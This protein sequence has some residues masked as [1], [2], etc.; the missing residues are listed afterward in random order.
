MQQKHVHII[1]FILAIGIVLLSSCG[2]TN[3]KRNNGGFNKVAVES[4][5][6]KA[7]GAGNDSV[8][9]RQSLDSLLETHKRDSSLMIAYYG[10]MGN[11]MSKHFDRL[12]NSSDIYYRRSIQLAEEQ[13]LYGMKIWALVNY[14]FYYYSYRQATEAMPLFMEAYFLMSKVADNEI[15]YPEDTFKKMGYYF[16][17]LGNTED[18]IKLL[19][20]AN[21][22][23]KAYQSRHKAGILDNLGLYYL[24]RQDTTAAIEHFLE[25]ESIALKAKDY[26]RYGKVLGNIALVYFNRG[27]YMEALRLINTDLSYSIA[28]NS[29]QNTMYA[30]VLK[31]KILLAMDSVDAAQKY[32]DRAEVY[33]RSKDYLTT[34]VLDI[35]R[36]RLQIAKINQD[37]KE[38]LAVRKRLDNLEEIA[39]KLDGERV[40]LQK[41]WEVD[42]EKNK[43][44]LIQSEANYKSERYMRIAITSLAAIIGIG[45]ILIL[46]N[47]KR[48]GRARELKYQKKVTELQLKKV[49]SDKRLLATKE[50]LSS[51]KEYLTD[52]NQQIAD[53]QQA[54]GRISESKSYYLEKEQGLLKDLLDSHLMTEDSWNSF[55]RSFDTQYPNFY[56]NLKSDFPE[57]TES[58]MRYIILAKLGLSLFEI[59]N[60]LGISTESVKKGRQRLKKK[61]GDRFKEFEQAV[62]G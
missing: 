8:A 14:G 49:I 45:L 15:A 56:Q 50:T 55:R 30:Q 36:L 13:G 32:L 38:E 57:L 27:E 47:L 17:T 18:A 2:D 4:L 48:V 33:A 58:N 5:L 61:I 46:S 29:Y 10:V 37:D 40:L 43:N 1:L 26:V 9:I 16:G 60:L 31:S 59:S 6:I 54:I 3:W 28:N 34:D 12:N 20:K 7:Q 19:D 62:Q 23:I 25:A 41:K 35:Q 24:E 44:A 21:V 53:L 22:H 11:T 51:Y 42:K 52:K 39:S